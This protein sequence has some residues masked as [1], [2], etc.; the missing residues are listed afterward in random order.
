MWF[1]VSLDLRLICFKFCFYIKKY[2]DSYFG[3]NNFK[4]YDFILI[5]NYVLVYLF[6]LIFIFIIDF[7][8]IFE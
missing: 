7:I 6:R 1:S 4:V 3:I 2:Y 5:E 8:E